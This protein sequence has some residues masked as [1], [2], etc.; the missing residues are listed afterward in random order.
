MPGGTID[1]QY[2]TPYFTHLVHHTLFQRGD[3]ICHPECNNAQPENNFDHGDCCTPNSE[4]GECIDPTSPHRYTKSNKSVLLHHKP[5]HN[6]RVPLP[7]C[8]YNTT[9]L[10]CIQASPIIASIGIS[11][12]RW[13]TNQCRIDSLLVAMPQLLSC[14]LFFRCFC[15]RTV[16][17][18]RLTFVSCLKMIQI[19]PHFDSQSLHHSQTLVHSTVQLVIPRYNSSVG[20]LPRARYPLYTRDREIAQWACNHENLGSHLGHGGQ[21]F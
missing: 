20:T 19:L 17:I 21:P 10:N 15:Q 16:D 5:I 12:L 11:D 18:T 2:C 14:S 8:P 13:K 6:H 4:F 3:G 7:P 9:I 1:K